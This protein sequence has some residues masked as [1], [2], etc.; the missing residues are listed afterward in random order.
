MTKP[1]ARFAAGS[2]AR[3]SLQRRLQRQRWRPERA[4]AGF[5]LA[6]LLVAVAL[7]G[8][9]S[10]LALPRNRH[11]LAR[12]R[13]DGTMQRLLTGLATARHRAETRQR[14]CAM[15]LE[16]AGWVPP[17]SNPRS[18]CS[19]TFAMDDTASS[20]VV[21]LDNFRKDI[22]I[23]AAGQLPAIG[24]T[25]VV[26]HRSLPLKRCFVVSGIGIVR[27]GRYNDERSIS[28]IERVESKQC[29][30]DEKY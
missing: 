14:A 1:I 3:A 4:S 6:E 19:I 7:L 18:G 30:R 10:G 13:R 28:A 8:L 25:V 23:N 24:G 9:L 11:Q 2:T 26:G 17:V 15:A 12:Q 22:T 5:S 16:S 27:T 20:G 29:V 21:I